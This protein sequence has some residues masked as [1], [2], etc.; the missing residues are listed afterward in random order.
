MNITLN[1]VFAD[2]ARAA[3]LDPEDWKVPDVK[4]SGYII[5]KFFGPVE[6]A[7]EARRVALT[8][9]FKTPR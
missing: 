5:P 7:A 8:F 1:D 4:I 3:G 2:M 9:T 6:A